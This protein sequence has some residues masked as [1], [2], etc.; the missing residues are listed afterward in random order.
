MPLENLHRNMDVYQRPE[1]QPRRYGFE[2]IGDMMRDPTDGPM[3]PNTMDNYAHALIEAF[4]SPVIR[5][6]V[7]EM[8]A[9]YENGELTVENVYERLYQLELTVHPT[10]ND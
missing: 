7:Q 10:P 8:V 4:D 6:A 1:L 3:N 9:A 2:T 5:E